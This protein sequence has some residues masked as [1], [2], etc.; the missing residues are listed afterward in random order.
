[1]DGTGRT[2][3]VKIATLKKGLALTEKDFF[4]I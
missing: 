1:V 3:Q 2:A 4:V